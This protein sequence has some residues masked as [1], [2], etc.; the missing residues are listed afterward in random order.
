MAEEMNPHL[1]TI[2]FQVAVESKKVSSEPPFLHIKEPQLPQL[3]LIQ[4]VLQI[5]PQLCSAALDT[6]TSMSSL[7]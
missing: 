4:L 6:S 1:T 2:S 7:K 3:L 5:L